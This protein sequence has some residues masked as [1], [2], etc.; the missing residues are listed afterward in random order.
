MTESLSP[1]KRALLAIETLQDRVDEL[2]SQRSEPIA[3]VGIG[4][5]MPGGVN[6]P[7]ALARLLDEGRCAVI[8]RPPTE[9]PGWT[10]DASRKLPPA[11]YLE[12]DPGAFDAE[13]FGISHR[14]AAS[15]DPQQRLVLEC[16]WEA[17]ENAGMAPAGLKNTRTGV[18]IGIT[19]SDYQQIQVRAGGAS[20]AHIHPHFASGAALSMASG[21]LS[22]LLGLQG[23][24]VSIDTA[25]SSTLVAVHLA[26]QS[27]RLRESDVAL[28]GGTSLIL[29]TDLTIAFQESRM[30]SPDGLCKAFDARADGFGRGEGCGIFVLKRLSDALAADDPIWAV[31][32]GSAVNQDGPSS[33]LTAPNG[34][35]QEAVI[36]AALANAGLEP[37]DVGYVEAHGTGT[38]LGDPIEVQALGAAYGRGRDEPLLI[39]TIKTNLGHLEG[40]SGVAGLLKAILA[41]RAGE[42]PP[43]L[44][45]ETPNPL[46]A[47][48]TLPVRVASRR[49]PFP[50]PGGKRRAGVSAFGF[51]GTNAHVIVEEPPAR[52]AAAAAL[53]ARAFSLLTLSAR[54]PAALDALASCYADALADGDCGLGDLCHTAAVGRT[55]LPRRL[56]IV[57]R[58]AEDAKAALEAYARGDRVGPALVHT[59]R[60][61]HESCR[62]VFLFTGQG[63]QRVGMGRELYDEEPVFKDVLDRCDAWLRDDLGVSLLDVMF[64]RLPDSES[65]LLRTRYAQPALYALEVALAEL[66]RSWGV[67]PAMV[68]G[69]SVGEYAAAAVS[70]AMSIEDGARLIAVRARLM[71]ALPTNG[72]MAAVSASAEVVESRLAGARTCIAAIN[73]PE[74]V[75]I[76][77]E[78]ESVE[79]LMRALAEA[80]IHSQRLRVSHAFHSPLIEPIMADLE[81]AASAVKFQRPRVPLV[82]NLTGTPVQAG[83]LADP[84][85]WSR[86]AREPVRFAASLRHAH[87]RGH[88]LFLECGPTPTLCAMGAETL[89]DAD[90]G[91]V[92]S[93]RRDQDEKQTIALAAGSLYVRGVDLDWA[94]RDRGRGHRRVRMPGYPFQRDVLWVRLPEA[95]EGEAS[96]ARRREAHPLLGWRSIT[97]DGDWRWERVLTSASLPYL[98]DHVVDG[99]VIA[100]AAALIEMALAAGRAGPGYTHPEIVDFTIGRPLVLGESPRVVH[101]RLKAAGPNAADHLTLTIH[102]LGGDESEFIQHAEALLRSGDAGQSVP[103]DRDAIAARCGRRLDADTFYMDLRERGLDFGPAL[104][105]VREVRYAVNEALGEIALPVEAGS[106]E[107]YSVHPA[108]LDAGLQVTA[109]ALRGRIEAAG[110]KPGL[111]L[112]VTAERIRRGPAEGQPSRCHA[113]LEAAEQQGTLIASLR[114]EDASGRLVLAIDR[115]VMKRAEAGKRPL[116]PVEAVYRTSWRTLP[117]YAG[118]PS[119]LDVDALAVALDAAIPPLVNEHELAEYDDLYVDLGRLSCAY[120]ARALHALGWSP[121]AGERVE[122]DEL[123]TRLGIRSRHRRLLGRFLTILAEDGLLRPVAGGYEVL[124]P[125]Q[126]TAPPAADEMRRRY[127]DAVPEL[128]ITRRCGEQLASVLAGKTDPLSILFPGGDTTMMSRLYRDTPIARAMNGVARLAVEAIVRMLPEG[129][130]LR[131]LEIGAGTGGTT[132]HVLPVLREGEV[133][134]TFTDIGTAFVTKAA[135][136]FGTRRA[137]MRF[138]TLDIDRDIREQGFEPAHYDLI[139]ASNVLHASKDIR[140]SL[141]RVRSLLAPNGVLLA[142]EAV[143]AE[144]WHDVTVGLLDGW[145]AFSDEAL[146]PDYPLLDRSRWLGVLDSLGFAAAS[147]KHVSSAKSVIGKQAAFFAQKRVDADGLGWLVFSDRAGI[148][149]AFAACIE[150]AGGRVTRVGTDV[151]IADAEAA[152]P[153]T[154]I[155]YFRGLD[156]SN[157][158]AVGTLERELESWCSEALELV[159]RV[160][161]AD[162]HPPRLHL[163]TRGAVAVGAPFERLCPSQATLW[164]LAR[165]AREERPELTV[166]TVDLP[167]NVGVSCAEELASLALGPSDEPE[168]ALRGADVFVPRL[169]PWPLPTRERK[170]RRLSFGPRGVLDELGFVEVPRE[171]PGPGQIEVAIEAAGLNF[172]DVMHALGMR[173]VGTNLGG[174]CVGIVTAVGEGVD[175]LRVG[176]RVLA[177][178]GAFGD[179]VTMH[180]GLA[181]RVPAGFSVAAAATL[182][183]AFLTAD[184][185][186]SDVGRM[187]AGETVLIH[188][189]AGGVG[190]AAVQLARAAGLRVFG[191]AGTDEKRARVLELGAEA[192]F[193][194]RSL[195]FVEQVLA[196][197]GGRGVDIVLNSLAG[198]FIPASL[199]VLAEGGRLLEL[200]KTGIWTQ[201]QVDARPSCKR[202]VRYEAVDL[203][204]VLEHAP[205]RIQERLE[206][207]MARFERGELV[208]LPHR[209][210]P[211]SRA[212]D[213]FRDMAAG[214]HIGK[215]V[216]VQDDELP[217]RRDGTYLVTGALSGL[218][219]L[220]AERLAMRGAGRLLL[221]GRNAPTE[222]AGRTIER[223]RARGTTVDVQLADV[224]KPNELGRVLASVDSRLPLRGVVHCAG[225]LDDALLPNQT[226]ERFR[227]VFNAKV[228]GTVALAEATASA[229][230]DFFVLFSS[231]SGVLGSPGQANHSAANAFMDA[232]AAHLVGRGRPAVSLAW[233]AWGGT[234]AAVRYRTVERVGR[235]GVLEIDPMLGLE[236]FERLACASGAVMVS[237]MDWSLLTT[238]RRRNPLIEHLAPKRG[239]AREAS[240]GRKPESADTIAAQVAAAA[241]RRRRQVLRKGVEQCVARVLGL[242]AG[243]VPDGRQPLGEIGLDSL[244]AIELRNALSAEIG[245]TLPASLLFDHPTIEALVEHLALRL[246]AA[247]ETTSQR[248]A[249]RAIE[250]PPAV[251][252]S[253]SESLSVL[254][255]IEGMS[256]QEVAERVKGRTDDRA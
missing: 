46:I 249:D 190:M 41:V 5:R 106:P 103:L 153:V 169:E 255:L 223:I 215:L 66:W 122:V 29:S 59:G 199:D 52:P 9:R 123:M 4:C 217:V 238:S 90:V 170:P 188:A 43:H 115:L 156:A 251:H 97:P 143:N 205:E 64:G 239:E 70:G 158:Q 189:A 157:E 140:A 57:C 134:Y 171:P 61:T 100:P 240:D 34:P 132:A 26:C 243:R 206:A 200:G 220:V 78:A 202:G 25:C 71:D 147:T 21:R 32:R 44:H 233:G 175:R 23:P 38:E 99:R 80:G 221:I 142:L 76:S 91:W 173:Y 13:L 168:L 133:E 178:A 118:I 137:D 225:V 131:V 105:G 65:L 130:R 176:D 10:V 14:E 92:A 30:L 165:A 232:F 116:A 68:I 51:S 164:G 145:W 87:G 96:P 198:E 214:R 236:L 110:S 177:A 213:A 88:R 219:L 162:E 36:A 208:P 254:E 222:D 11:G 185:A 126:N 160:A 62:P 1:L 56:A 138:Q 79:A 112:P 48:E 49:T 230:L 120:V 73:G 229:P 107:G 172:R 113:V 7:E 3:V 248:P 141:E 89:R 69:H 117:V 149:D 93:M 212:V 104:R 114:M 127:G 228:L 179:Y 203:S 33:G 15:I 250:P 124:I 50:A 241:P 136:E 204:P 193:D 28:A 72:A 195:D 201:E 197:T 135:A 109:A 17:L 58:S 6:S 245:Q 85:Y 22:Y 181:V 54:T 186:L 209:T 102:S 234:G 119:R 63:S 108:L 192:V 146:R 84:R 148:A 82:S 210:V 16:A 183:I 235:S 77:G 154:D 163:V 182:P 166:R 247:G 47:W 144:R 187:R 231:V 12:C 27:L 101:V 242:P 244:L 167:A 18:F 83:D 31:I 216:L 129:R 19:G 211:M 184:Y 8:E 152:H 74:S 42:I 81:R 67:E 150:R 111:Y 128:E 86:H 53:P 35:S 125:P 174:E 60:A 161:D 121:A 95:M 191:T 226:W 194:S 37:R 20:R 227:R 2:E 75:V 24:S 39:G 55:H 207:L 139:L 159:K 196:A 246:D 98:A 237:P 155:A 151:R 253:V 40:A 256:D 45:F 180:S 224:G 218:G 252:A 94:A